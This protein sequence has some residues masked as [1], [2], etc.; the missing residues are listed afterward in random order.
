ME[1]EKSII[2]KYLQNM[3]AG[4]VY[5]NTKLNDEKVFYITDA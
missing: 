3:I 4:Q 1:E 5:L 2:K